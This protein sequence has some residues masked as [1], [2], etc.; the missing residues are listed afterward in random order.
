[1][2]VERQKQA[3]EVLR[4]GRASL[5]AVGRGLIADPDWPLKVREGRTTDIVACTGCDNC[6]DDLAKGRPVGCVQ[7]RTG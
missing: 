1:M 4:E 3:L 2:R 5:V 6:F 7:W